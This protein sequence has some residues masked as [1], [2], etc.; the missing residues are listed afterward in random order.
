MVY[1]YCLKCKSKRDVSGAHAVTMKN[2]KP[3][4]HGVCPECST[5]V[6]R[7]GKVKDGESLANI[8]E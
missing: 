1:I 7:I 6:F 8:L 5:K 4:I 2:G 3:A